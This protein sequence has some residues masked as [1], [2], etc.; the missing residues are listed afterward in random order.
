MLVLVCVFWILLLMI[1][2]LDIIGTL[3]ICYNVL[4][5]V[6]FVNLV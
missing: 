3:D 1:H 2:V 5:C 6:D 4:K